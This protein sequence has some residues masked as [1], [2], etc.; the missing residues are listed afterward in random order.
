MTPLL[1]TI[2]LFGLLI[3]LLFFGAPLIV[4]IGLPTAAVMLLS[5]MPVATFAQRMFVAVD[6]F[7]MMAIP[8]FML[9]GKLM[10]VGGM[11]RRI[12]RFAN[13]LVGWLKGGLAHVVIVAC[14]FFGALSGSAAAT[15]AA[16][17]STLIPDMKKKVI[18]PTSLPDLRQ[19]RA[20][21][22]LSF[23]RVSR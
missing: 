5:G 21:W 9:A 22:V 16:I 17:G 7:T 14:A 20:A 4:C 19:L 13:A 3:A 18:L 15:C 6:S 12:V 8:F 11:S 10:E 2:V 23:L 1:T